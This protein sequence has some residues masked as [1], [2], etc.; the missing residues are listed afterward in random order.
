MYV[1][2][3]I[4]RHALSTKLPLRLDEDVIERVKAYAAERGTSVSRLGEEYFASVTKEG[5]PGP[6]LLPPFTKRLID[7]A[8]LG[9]D[10]SGEDDYEC[11]GGNH[12]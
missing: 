7:R 12:Q 10:L 4:R 2:L 11:V 8:P 9:G 1:S 5:V 3:S 6:S